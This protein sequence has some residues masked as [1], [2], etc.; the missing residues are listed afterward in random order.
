MWIEYR[1]NYVDFAVKMQPNPLKAEH[2]NN[3]A[4]QEPQRKM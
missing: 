1:W 3:I 2:K 4:G